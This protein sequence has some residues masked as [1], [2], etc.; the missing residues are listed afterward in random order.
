MTENQNSREQLNLWLD[1]A[2]QIN[3]LEDKSVNK[4]QKEVEK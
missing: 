3:E 4:F 2:E 1:T